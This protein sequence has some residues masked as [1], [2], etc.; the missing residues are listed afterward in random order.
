MSAAWHAPALA[1]GDRVVV[2][3]AAVRGTVLDL[4]R[5]EIVRLE[6]DIDYCRRLRIPVHQK[7][8]KRLHD[9]RALSEELAR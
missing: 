2:I 8:H 7:I 1:E 3:T 9:M 6:S 4:V 5:Q